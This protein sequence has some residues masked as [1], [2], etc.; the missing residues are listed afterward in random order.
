MNPQSTI[1]EP[2][3]SI[4]TP[5]INR[6]RQFL[7][8]CESIERQTYPHWEHVIVDDGSETDYVEK[9][10]KILYPEEKYKIIR[11]EERMERLISYNDGMKKAKGDWIVFLD[12]DDEYIPFYLEYLAEAIAKFPDYKV[13]NYGGLVT[14]KKD[15]WV[16]ARDVVPFHHEIGAPVESGQIVNGQF[17]FHKSCLKKTGYFPE[18]RNCYEFADKAGIPGYDSK[19]RTLGNPFG[20]DFFLFY[21]LT[22]HYISL[23]LSLYLYICH[24]RGTE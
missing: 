14:N 6:P 16:R 19:T 21:K 2:F 1:S 4:I 23:P 24:I 12:D 18:V 9:T 10:V 20:N 13:F 3:F 11:H 8:A 7:R 22:R 5:T 17:A 15:L